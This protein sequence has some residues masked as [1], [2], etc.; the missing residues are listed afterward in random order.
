MYLLDTDV[1][2]LLRRQARF[3]QVAA[4]F[5]H[6]P[7]AAMHISVVTIAEVETGIERAARRNPIF[8]ADLRDGILRMCEVEFSGRILSVDADVARVWGQMAARIGKNTTAAGMRCGL[9]TKWWASS[10]RAPRPSTR[11]ARRD[12]RPHRR[13]RA[14]GSGA[15][16]GVGGGWCRLAPGRGAPPA[17]GCGSTCC[18][19]GKGRSILARRGSGPVNPAWPR[20][21]SGLAWSVFVQ[22]ADGT[23]LWEDEQ[24]GCTAHRGLSSMAGSLRIAGG[25]AAM[26]EGVA[27]AFAVGRLHLNARRRRGAGR[28]A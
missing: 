24:G 16:G 15:G 7:L 19:T 4:W 28:M 22:H 11:A 6:R 8:A 23:I 5:A 18:A 20:W 1:L 25:M 12:G 27:A 21:W 14:C 10:R 9:P 17:W 2:S 26:I 3:P 13:R